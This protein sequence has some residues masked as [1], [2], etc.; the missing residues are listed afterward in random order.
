MK[1]LLSLL[2]F[3]VLSFACP[4]DHV[5]FS[6]G[7]VRAMAPGQEAAAVY[8]HI[9]NTSDKPI[10]IVSV[11]SPDVPNV[12]IHKSIKKH[13]MVE[14]KAMKHLVL[15][16]HTTTMLMPGGEHIMLMGLTSP[17]VPTSKPITLVFTY[18]D[19]STSTVKAIPVKD[20]RTE[21]TP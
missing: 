7:Y 19:K 1:R 13:D 2:L 10:T 5:K 9:E 20:M 14:M 21:V 8:M 11:S 12:M 18:S 4:S 6:Q 16:P 15:L 17:L 3:P